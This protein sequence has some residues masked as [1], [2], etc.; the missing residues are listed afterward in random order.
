MTQMGTGRR[1]LIALRIFSIFL[2]VD[3]VALGFLLAPE[4]FINYLPY[5]WALGFGSLLASWVHLGIFPFHSIHRWAAQSIGPS[6]A[7]LFTICQ[8][9]IGFHFLPHEFLQL[10]YSHESKRL[11][12]IIVIFH[13]FWM[14]ILSI[15]ERRPMMLLIHSILT[16]SGLTLILTPNAHHAFSLAGPWPWLMGLMATLG[17]FADE[18]HNLKNDTLAPFEHAQVGLLKR[19]PQLHLFTQSLIYTFS[20]CLLIIPFWILL[21]PANN[22][23]DHIDIALSPPKIF[24]IILMFFSF[25]IL[26]LH[27]ALFQLWRRFNAIAPAERMVF[28]EGAQPPIIWRWHLCGIWSVGLLFTGA[29]LF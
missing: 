6:A 15:G 13:L 12:T 26:S 25:S 21:L 5:P 11:F 19:W 29:Y 23:F 1:S 28:P 16:L 17:L 20:I 10:A 14:G 24:F 22:I 8:C 3:S 9:L 7:I 2:V 18:L 4:S 27:T